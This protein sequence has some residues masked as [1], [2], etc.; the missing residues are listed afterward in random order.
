MPTHLRPLD[1]DATS[2]KSKYHGWGYGYGLHIVSTQTAFPTLMT[3][4]SASVS[5]SWVIDQKASEILTHLSPKTLTA[6][7]AYTQA[8]RI[9]RWAKAQVEFAPC[10]G[11]TTH[12]EPATR[13]LYGYRT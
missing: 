4:Q 13:L 6:D 3:V 9:R 12:P 11:F 8:S 1:T 10:L 7:D 5:E 2:S